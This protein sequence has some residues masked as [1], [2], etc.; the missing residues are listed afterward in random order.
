MA[1]PHIIG[2]FEEILRGEDANIIHENV[3]PRNR[4]DKRGTPLCR[5]EI[6][7]WAGEERLARELIPGEG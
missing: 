3:R 4:F 5:A 1:L 7:T 2:R 6:R